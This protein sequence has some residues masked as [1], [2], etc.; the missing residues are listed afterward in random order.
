MELFPYDLSCLWN[1][2]S[3]SIFK[4][5]NFKMNKKHGFFNGF[6]E[7]NKKF[8][9]N[10]SSITNSIFLFLVFVFGIGITSIF[11]K[12][13]QKKFLDLKIEKSIPSYWSTI[14]LN[15]KSLQDYYRQF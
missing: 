3:W 14:N 1:I 13:L 7:G 12:F 5:K 9:E 6:K 4:E 8:T 10:I 15:K 2:S 11:S